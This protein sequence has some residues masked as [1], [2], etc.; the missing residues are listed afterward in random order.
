MTS[1][2]PGVRA[3]GVRHI[4]LS[5]RAP[6]HG[7][8]VDCNIVHAHVLCSKANGVCAIAVIDSGAPEEGGPVRTHVV[9]IAARPQS[10]FPATRRAD[11][12]PLTHC[13]PPLVPFEWTP[14][15]FV[16]DEV[17]VIARAMHPPF[18]IWRRLVRE[19]QLYPPC[20]RCKGRAVSVRRHGREHGG[21][22]WRIR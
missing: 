12:A 8:A 2:H 4:T 9:P 6:T 17:A 20:L 22:P 3:Q 15:R 7:V 1:F 21:A 16:L 13:L 11:T 14:L 5:M 18:C 19:S 10:R